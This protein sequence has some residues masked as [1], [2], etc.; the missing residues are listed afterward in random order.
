M[1]ITV[2]PLT[3]NSGLL[4]IQTQLTT[5]RHYSHDHT[6]G[7]WSTTCKNYRTAQGTA[8]IRARGSGVYV[9]R[10]KD[11]PGGHRTAGIQRITHE[12]G[13]W[14]LLRS[15]KV[16]ETT[17]ISARY[18]NM[19]NQEMVQTCVCLD[20]D[21]SVTGKAWKTRRMWLCRMLYTRYSWKAYTNLWGHC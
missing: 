16:Q 17:N 1:C 10:A 7:T 9:R 15:G 8:A 21:E 11:P 5:L 3:V 20:T 12:T 18:T 2:G 13:Q 4:Y 6:K 19:Y 14:P